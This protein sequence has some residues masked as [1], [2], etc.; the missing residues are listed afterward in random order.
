[1]WTFIFRIQKLLT[2]V[3]RY[4]VD[5]AEKFTFC[6]CMNP[7][8]KIDYYAVMNSEAI[9]QSPSA[10]LE[11]PFLTKNDFSHFCVRKR[12]LRS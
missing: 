4:V 8:L 11:L 10:D 7:C 2:F 9:V 3:A 6:I 5:T 1:M 12:W